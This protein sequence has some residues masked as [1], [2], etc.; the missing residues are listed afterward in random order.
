MVPD[1]ELIAVLLRWA[2]NSYFSDID[3][4][5]SMC[6]DCVRPDAAQTQPP[7]DKTALVRE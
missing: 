5:H 7:A 4:T 3:L 1:E 6:A 2:A